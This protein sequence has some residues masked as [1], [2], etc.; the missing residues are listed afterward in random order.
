M[1]SSSQDT[2]SRERA[3]RRELARQRLMADRNARQLKLMGAIPRLGAIQD[4]F[5]HISLDLGRLALGEPGKLGRNVDELRSLAESLREER[6]RLLMEHRIPP[7][8]LEVWW[9]CP[10][11]QD[12]GYTGVQKCLCL[13]QEEIDDLYHRSGLPPALLAQTFDRFDLSLYPPDVREHMAGV[14]DDCQRFA[15]RVVAVLPTDGIVIIGGVGRGKTFLCSAIA[16]Q[17]LQAGRTCIYLTFANLLD[18]IREARFEESPESR[19]TL[20]LLESVDLL[21]L[22]DLG[23]EKPSEF[24]VQELFKVINARINARRPTV[25]STNLTM[26]QLEEVYT[27]RVVSR[28]IGTSQLLKVEGEDIRLL[29]KTRQAPQ[30]RPRAGGAAGGGR[31]DRK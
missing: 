5:A 31:G 12:T 28:I 26:T 22:D 29:K 15:G 24:V 7:G 4:R 23:A 17:V 20:N 8:Y 19:M 27:V 25:V 2:I 9:H 14:R 30:A 10:K 6:D 18:L 11:C 3:S 13:V 16:N 1:S 21:T